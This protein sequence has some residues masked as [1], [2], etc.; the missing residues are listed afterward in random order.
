MAGLVC[1]VEG[2]TAFTITWQ[3]F[4]TEYNKSET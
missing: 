4:L 3:L 1:V 2:N